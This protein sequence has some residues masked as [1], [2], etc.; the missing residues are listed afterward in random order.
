MHGLFF[1]NLHKKP[2]TVVTSREGEAEAIGNSMR[3]TYFSL[4]PFG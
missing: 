2:I 4:L 1:G 3:E